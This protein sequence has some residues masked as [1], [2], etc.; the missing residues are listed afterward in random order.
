MERFW[1]QIKELLGNSAFGELVISREVIDLKVIF[2][3]LLQRGK[4][5][6]ELYEQVA[7]V[8]EK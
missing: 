5:T 4:I 6:K 7:N 8:F 2:E 3:I 1:L